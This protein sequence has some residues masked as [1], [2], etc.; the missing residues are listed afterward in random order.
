LDL[1]ASCNENDPNL[2]SNPTPYFL[3]PIIVKCSKLVTM[4]ARTLLDFGALA[5]FMDK[6][7]VRQYNLALVGKNIPMS[8]EVING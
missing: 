8:V 5:C 6:K 2:S 1:D 4:E 3:V 7:L